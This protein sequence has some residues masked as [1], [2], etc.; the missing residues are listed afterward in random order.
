MAMASET[1][2]YPPSD[3]L[4]KLFDIELEEVIQKIFLYLDPISLKNSRST[5]KKWNEFIDRRI[6]KSKSGML[7]MECKLIAQ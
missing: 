6:W 7:E 1:E 5:C 2:E 4:Q 3:I